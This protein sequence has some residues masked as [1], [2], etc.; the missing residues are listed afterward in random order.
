MSKGC[1]EECHLFRCSLCETRR[2]DGKCD[3]EFKPK[4]EYD[5]AGRRIE[6]VKFIFR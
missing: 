3:R 6:Q 1:D 2:K 5:D 4:G